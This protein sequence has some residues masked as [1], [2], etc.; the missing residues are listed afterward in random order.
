MDEDDYDKLKEKCVRFR[1][2][3]IGR[4][5]AGK[6]TIL[7]RIAQ[8]ADGRVSLLSILS[9]ECWIRSGWPNIRCMCRIVTQSRANNP[10]SVAAIG[11]K[12]NWSLIAI[13]DSYF[14]TRAEL[15]LVAQ[16]KSMPF[17]PSYQ[18]VRVRQ[19]WL[20]SF[21]QS[22]KRLC[23]CCWCS[24]WITFRYCIPTDNHRLVLDAEL[25]FFDK[26][27]PKGGEHFPQSFF[28]K[29]DNT[30]CPL[31]SSSPN[32]KVK[33]PLPFVCSNNSIQLK[34]HCPKPHSKHEIA[35]TK[36]IYLDSQVKNMHLREY[37]I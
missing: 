37:C 16:R 14:T 33:K 24:P 1:A 4:P 6:T 15:K 34:K 3:I 27:D 7:R 11:S 9:V 31:S 23:R 29:I 19:G 28:V 36:N 10:P 30:Q 20:I 18:N 12:R 35:L 32:S 13:L 25:Q 22:G 26:I 2:L 17:R 5:N 21:M 8:A